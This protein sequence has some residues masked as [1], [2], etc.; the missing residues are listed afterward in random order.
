METG[1]ERD[2]SRF[3]SRVAAWA[4]GRRGSLS[5]ETGSRRHLEPGGEEAPLVRSTF[6]YQPVPLGVLTREAQEN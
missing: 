6:H 1:C 2:V 4:L 5:L 3:P